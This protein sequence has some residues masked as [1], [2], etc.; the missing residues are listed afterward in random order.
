MMRLLG[1]G[2]YAARGH[3]LRRFNFFCGRVVFWHGIQV[4]RP[5]I[6]TPMPIEHEEPR[7]LP[8]LKVQRP[9]LVPV[10]AL[11]AVAD[12]RLWASDVPVK[13]LRNF[14]EGVMG[15]KFEE[16]DADRLVFTQHRRKI[17]LVRERL[18]H[19]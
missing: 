7:K 19:G 16:G 12:V 1:P 2:L 18:E 17:L 15:L 4:K 13:A 8:P 5:V 3:I 14:Y 6:L 11:I 10:D 9:P